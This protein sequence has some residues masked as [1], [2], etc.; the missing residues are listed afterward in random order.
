MFVFAI[1]MLVFL[2]IIGLVAW[3]I[4]KDWKEMK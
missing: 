1:A 3:V 4:I 2:G